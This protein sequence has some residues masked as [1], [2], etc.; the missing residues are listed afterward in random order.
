MKTGELVLQL[1][2][3]RLQYGLPVRILL[4]GAI[5]T[6]KTYLARQLAGELSAEFFQYSCH[7]ESGQEF[8]RVPDLDGIVRGERGYSPGPALAAALASH[9]G[10]TVLLVDEI[11]KAPRGFEAF[12][13]QFLQ[14]GELPD[15]EG[16]LIRAREEQLVITITSNARR[17]LLE[18]TQR[19]LVRFYFPRLTGQ[20][21]EELVR[22]CLP[23]AP[24]VPEG[25]VKLLVRLGDEIAKVSPEDAPAPQ[26]LA[27]LGVNLVL[28]SDTLNVEGVRELALSALVKERGRGEQLLRKLP[29]DYRKALLTEAL[30]GR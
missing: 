28:L 15:L 14:Y 22:K 17:P 9:E 8:W 16:R 30:R 24:E 29:F 18:E 1:A 10:Y 26:E 20:A 6:G 21:L 27:G 12:L 5:G 23:P 4:E 2:R 13:L 25:L 11:D 3:Q 7:P 19:R